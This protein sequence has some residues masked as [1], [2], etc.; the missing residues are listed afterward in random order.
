MR[1]TT[2]TNEQLATGGNKL[3][4]AMDPADLERIGTCAR[5]ETLRRRDIISRADVPA[6]AA[7]FVESGVVSVFKPDSLRPTEI[8]LVGPEG[9]TGTMLIMADGRWPY[10]TFVQ[11]DEVRAIRIEA[12]D[13]LRIVAQSS[14]LRTLLMTAIHLQTIQIAEGLISTAWQQI[15]ARL[16]RW[17]LM[18]RDRM[19][20]DRLEVTHEFMALMVGAQRTGITAALH[21]LEGQ[22]AIRAT[23][24]RVAIR[25]VR[26]L[27]AAADGGYGAAER[28]RERLLAT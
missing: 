28:E 14:S 4:A 6:D 23:R 24:G 3:L 19:H 16:A 20:S 22:G 26:I 1:V 15:N 21:E 8:C 9:F 27:E 2:L 11:T 13:L 12:K 7:F 5:R 10:E 18:Y 25:D 17:L